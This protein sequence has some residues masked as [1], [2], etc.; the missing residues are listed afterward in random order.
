MTSDDYPYWTY[1]DL[2]DLEYYEW[3]EEYQHMLEYVESVDADNVFYP[4]VEYW[5]AAIGS[6]KAWT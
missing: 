6:D 2:N 5:D 4:P 1:E 3:C